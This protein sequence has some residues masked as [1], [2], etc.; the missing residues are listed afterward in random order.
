MPLTKVSAGVIAANAVQESVGSQSITGDKL[1]LT[2]INANNIVNASITGAKIALGTITG[3]DIATGQITGNLIATNAISQNNIISVNA[4]VITV[5][6]LPKARLPS[7]TVLQVVSNTKT[8]TFSTVS[9]S[10]VDITGFSVSITP[11]SVTSRIL[12]TYTINV[13]YDLY[14][15]LAVQLVRDST[16]ICI[17]DAAASRNRASN[18]TGQDPEGTYANRNIICLNNNF[19]DSPA[20]TSATTYKLQI[21]AINETDGTSVYVNRTGADTNEAGMSRVTS[22]I[23]VMEIAG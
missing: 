13:G 19:L 2:A 7:N 14:R 8:D 21:G 15:G 20:T 17:G 10:Y 11:T 3:D 4:S 23:T 9:T 22:T 16:A 5:G 1:G 12:I 6:T 18:F